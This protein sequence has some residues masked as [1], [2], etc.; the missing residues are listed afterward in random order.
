MTNNRDRKSIEKRL[1]ELL[2]LVLL[3]SLGVAVV[4]SW[5]GE[6]AGW[7]IKSLLS[8]EGLRWSFSHLPD[9]LFNTGTAV[10]WLLLTVWGAIDYTGFGRVFRALTG[11]T[12]AGR[13]LV[14]LRQRHA[15]WVSLILLLV[16]LGV[17]LMWSVLPHA[18]LLSATGR[19]YP[20]PFIHGLL[21]AVALGVLGVMLLY[22]LL[23]N[24]LRTMA[25][26]A[27]MFFYG[28]SRHADWLCLYVLA[29]LLYACICY[30][31]GIS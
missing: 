23:S 29:S 1:P 9:R 22:G 28:V 10:C 20:S 5:I 30:M 7:P 2:L 18:I 24:R 17:L 4:G 14:S 21:P 11:R 31:I 13:M 25:E 6:A 3:L 15:L 27:R 8:A 12:F 26:V 19:V 16:W